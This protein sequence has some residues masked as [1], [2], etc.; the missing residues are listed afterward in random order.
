MCARDL[1]GIVA[2]ESPDNFDHIV[3]LA[4]S[5]INDVTNIQLLCEVCNHRK[6]DGDESTSS[7]YERWFRND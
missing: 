4:R 2:I 3:S 6:S 5:G 1:S 7:M